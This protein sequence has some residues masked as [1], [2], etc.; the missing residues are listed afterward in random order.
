MEASEL[1]E[2]YA[3]GERDFSGV[4]C[5]G[6]DLCGAYLG[7]SDFRGANFGEAD[8]T[9]A[10]LLRAD[11][12]EADLTGATLRDTDLRWANFDFCKGIVTAS[13]EGYPLI[14]V[15]G[16]TPMIHSGCRWFTIPEAR[17]HL[18]PD[19]MDKWTYQTPEWGQ[20]RLAMVNFL[21]S[22]L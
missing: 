15:K 8:L 14:L 12:R 2:R 10:N 16:E 18:R 19:N 20:T 11:F 6:A 13:N 9:G 5:S 3:N 4:N 1:L 21:E 7:G 22:Q 17:E